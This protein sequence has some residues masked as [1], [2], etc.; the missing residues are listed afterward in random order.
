[1][2][3]GASLFECQHMETYMGVMVKMLCTA[4]GTGGI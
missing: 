1:M 4:A 3:T 2:G